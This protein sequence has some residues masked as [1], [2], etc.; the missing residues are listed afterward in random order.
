MSPNC[1]PPP[2]SFPSCCCRR[3]SRD[4]LDTLVDFPLRDLDMAPYLLSRQQAAQQQQQGQ[5]GQEQPHAKY[6]LYAV[7]NHYGGE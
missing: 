5:A 3:Y 1:L 7:S 6:D 4:K 2:P